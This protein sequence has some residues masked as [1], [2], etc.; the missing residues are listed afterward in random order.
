MSQ[1][2]AVALWQAP[3][4][5]VSLGSFP[6]RFHI[7]SGLG[8]SRHLEMELVTTLQDMVCEAWGKERHSFC[9]L[10]ISLTLKVL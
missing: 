3:I 2:G 4:W 9:D 6:V 8:V 7:L 10:F 1:G 5:L